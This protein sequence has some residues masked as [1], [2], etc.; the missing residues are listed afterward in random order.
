[1]PPQIQALKVARNHRASQTAL[2][3]MLGWSETLDEG[4][5]TI[6][7]GEG[8]IGKARRVES[9]AHEWSFKSIQ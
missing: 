3:V 5:G 9:R 6:Q 8:G 4:H 7:N 1:M 2:G